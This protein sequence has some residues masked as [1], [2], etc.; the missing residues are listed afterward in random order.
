MGFAIAPTDPASKKL[1]KTVTPSDC[2]H[3][4]VE[5]DGI[6]RLLGLVVIRLPLAPSILTFWVLS[7]LG[8]RLP[9]IQPQE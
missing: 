9:R 4:D 7:R 2:G 6:G 1:S 3:P 5:M 8:S